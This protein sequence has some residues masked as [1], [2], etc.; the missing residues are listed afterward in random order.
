MTMDRT[1]AKVGRAMK[2]RDMAILVGRWTSSPR[3]AGP[4]GAASGP[5][6]LQAG[7]RPAPG[8]RAAANGGGHSGTSPYF[9]PVADADFAPLLRP[10]PDA[11]SRVLMS[12]G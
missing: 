8:S 9:D 1:H 7:Q 10:G 12:T 6:E 4:C 2:N 3:F 5:A 11:G